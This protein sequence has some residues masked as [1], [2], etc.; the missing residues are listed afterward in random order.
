MMERVDCYNE[1]NEPT[2]TSVPRAD[3]KDHSCYFRVVHLWWTD[4]AKWLVQKRAKT[5]DVIPFM[6]AF[7]HGLVT[8]GETPLEAVIRETYE[9]LGAALLQETLTLKKMVATHEG[10]Y[11]TFVYVYQTTQKPPPFTL[12]DEV[13]EV[14]WWDDQTIQRAIA[15]KHFWDYPKL[16]RFN[17]YF[18]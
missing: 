13:L 9:E 8:A 10:P 1:A 7:T 2:G 15:K 4:E 16:L 11:K 17:D 14:A 5:D 18:K 12:S 6:W 3:L